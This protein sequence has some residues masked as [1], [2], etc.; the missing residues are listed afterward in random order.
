[1]HINR[2]IDEE[3][4]STRFDA[5]FTWTAYNKLDKIYA[6]LDEQIGKHPNILKNLEIAT[7]YEN[8]TVRGV[9]LSKKPVSMILKCIEII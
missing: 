3:T 1:M 5:G 7:S 4:D 2:H 8:R 6:W 9:L